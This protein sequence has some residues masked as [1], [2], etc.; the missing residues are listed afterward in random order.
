MT[1]GYPRT[2]IKNKSHRI[3]PRLD[4]E[5]AENPI[6]TE[7][8]PCVYGVSKAIKYK[9]QS[10]EIRTAFK[11]VSMLH[12]SLGHVKDRVPS[13]DRAA[14]KFR[15]RLPRSVHG[16]ARQNPKSKK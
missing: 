15:W 5:G 9:L 1:N 8:I 7:V 16:T 14:V 11:P 10:V 2:F 13:E 6:A 3:F 12:K 4:A